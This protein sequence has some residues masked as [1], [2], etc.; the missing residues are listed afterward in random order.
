MP[1]HHH[2]ATGPEALT[3][4]WDL[5]LATPIGRLGAVLA[6]TGSGQDLSGTATGQGEDVPLR[7]L[8]LDRDRLSWKQSITRPLRLDLAF[9]VTVAGDTL[10][11]TSR[12]GRLPATKVT[13]V[14]RPASDPRTP[15]T[16][17]EARA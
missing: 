5:T 12:A 9:A 15:G 10:S 3:G 4:T 13:G 11:G 2:P 7:E 1:T 17:P 8:V 6:L 14:R 16:G